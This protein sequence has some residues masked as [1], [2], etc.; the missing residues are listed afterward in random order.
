MIEHEGTM[1]A[2]LKKYGLYNKREDY[3]DLCYIGYAK[4]KNTFDESKGSFRNYLYNC[5]ENEILSELTKQSRKKRQRIES[6]MDYI[7]DEQGQSINNFV[8]DIFNLEE[9]IITDETNKNLYDKIAT[10]E[11]I[12]QMVIN[13]LFELT[14]KKYTQNDIAEQLGISQ[15]QVSIIKNEALEKLKGKLIC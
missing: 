6:S 3:I 8:A 14:E 13:N 1:Y 2:V 9:S 15:T 5:C 10:L 12:E 4:A 11:P 7:F